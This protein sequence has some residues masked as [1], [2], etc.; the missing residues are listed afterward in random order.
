LK[1]DEKIDNL[2]EVQQKSLE[3]LEQALTVFR[4]IERELANIS[5]SVTKQ[6]TAVLGRMNQIAHQ[7]EVLADGT[8]SL[9]KCVFNEKSGES[10]FECVDVICQQ[11]G[12][13]ATSL[14]EED[15]E[16]HYHPDD[17][18]DYHAQRDFE[19]SEE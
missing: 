3:V 14:L 19:S 2:L 18:E 9:I 10:I 15:L 16:R 1:L 11:T 13:I 12:E 5:G 8:T 7:Q 17:R 6:G 4:G